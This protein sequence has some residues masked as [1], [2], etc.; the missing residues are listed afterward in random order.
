[1]KF[2]NLILGTVAAAAF[3]ISCKDD[4]NNGGSSAIQAKWNLISFILNLKQ[5]DRW[6]PAVSL[7]LPAITLIFVMTKR[8]M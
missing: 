3:L 8:S 1:M 4:D 2:K 5:T 6:I 7:P